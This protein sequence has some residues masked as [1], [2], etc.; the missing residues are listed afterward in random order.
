MGRSD[1]AAYFFRETFAA[2]QKKRSGG[3]VPVFTCGAVMR[4]VEPAIRPCVEGRGEDEYGGKGVHGGG[5]F[6]FVMV[7]VRVLLQMVC[8]VYRCVAGYREARVCGTVFFI[9]S[10][11]VFL[12]LC[13]V[14]FPS[15]GSIAASE[16]AKPASEPHRSFSVG[17]AALQAL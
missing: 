12:L 7:F 9:V 1:L 15:F 13:V 4:A 16:R 10:L 8:C 3:L 2:S 5:V 6:P 14:F 11:R 17:V